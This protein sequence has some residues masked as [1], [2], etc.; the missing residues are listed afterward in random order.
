MLVSVHLPKTAGI[1]FKATLRAHYG[2]RL[3]EDYAD[4]PIHHSRRDR[5]L[6]AFRAGLDAVATDVSGV[7]CIH[8]HFMPLKYLP[9]ST[10]REVAF[11]TWM[12][13]PIERLW[14]HY[15]YWRDEPAPAGVRPLRRRMLDEAWSFERFAKAQ[16]LRDF[17]GQFLFGFPLEYFSFIGIT[18]RY[19]EDHAEFTRRFLG[20]ERPAV[21]LNTARAAPAAVQTIPQALRQELE[22]V[23]AGDM[24]LYRRALELRHARTGD[25]QAAPVGIVHPA[26]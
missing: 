4:L 12:R 23:H 26:Q 9:L 17:Y 14:S 24:A 1:S 19:D 22:S 6:H 2:D 21:R 25:G 18:E 16:E 15:R 11:V 3:R 13:D 7:Q 5:T 8:G 20:S 10:T